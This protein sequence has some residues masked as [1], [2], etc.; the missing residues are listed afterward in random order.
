MVKVVLNST[1]LFDEDLHCLSQVNDGNNFIILGATTSRCLALFIAHQGEVLCKKNLLHDGWGKFGTVV[2]EG[3]L[4]QM[5][6]QLRKAFEHFN[7]DGGLIITMPRVGYKLS[8]A[9]VIEPEEKLRQVI[10]LPAATELLTLHSLAP[11][12]RLPAR[13]LTVWLP[14]LLLNLLLLALIYRNQSGP[15]PLPAMQSGWHF[16]H[17][18]Q[19]TAIYVQNPDSSAHDINQRVITLMPDGTPAKYVYIN[20][21]AEQTL[22]SYFLCRREIKEQDNGCITSI[23]VGDSSG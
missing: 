8:T 13:W 20:H 10:T 4:W 12:A 16:S 6:S 22:K 21:S 9:L 18:A 19:D 3:S 7:L 11:V 14:L 15:V 5:I 1:I 23:M 2:S 17:Q